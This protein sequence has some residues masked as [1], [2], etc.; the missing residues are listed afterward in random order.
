VPVLG[1]E[2]GHGQRHCPADWPSSF[3]HDESRLTLT[4][5]RQILGRTDRLAWQ[6]DVIEKT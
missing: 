6:P 5:F 3:A 2:G 4:L 1:V